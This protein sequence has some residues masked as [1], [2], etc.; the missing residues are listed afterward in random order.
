LEKGADDRLILGFGFDLG[1]GVFLQGP[2]VSSTSEGNLG[3]KDVAKGFTHFAPQAPG[4]VK[5]L[6]QDFSGF[7][8]L[9]KGQPDIA[10]GQL[11]LQSILAL[12]G[13]EASGLAFNTPQGLTG[14]VMDVFD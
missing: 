2:I 14:M 12:D 1:G 9:R 4:Q 6:M 10:P 7:I 8:G 3:G 5:A 13:I 11:I